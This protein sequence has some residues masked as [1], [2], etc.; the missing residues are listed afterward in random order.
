M[1]PQDQRS[2][3][4]MESVLSNL[5]TPF[6]PDNLTSKSKDKALHTSRNNIGESKRKAAIMIDDRTSGAR[7]LG[8]VSSEHKKLNLLSQV[9]AGQRTQ[10]TSTILRPLPNARCV[11]TV[12]NIDFNIR[13][14]LLP[15]TMTTCEFIFPC[16]SV[17][18][19]DLLEQREQ[20]QF[21]GGLMRGNASSLE[22][23]LSI[24][25]LLKRP[26]SISLHKLSYPGK[27]RLQELLTQSFP[28]S[29]SLHNVFTF[30]IHQRLDYWLDTLRRAVSQEDKDCDSNNKRVLAAL[31]DVQSSINV[32]SDLKINFSIN[33]EQ[34]SKN[35]DQS[36]ASEEIMMME[37]QLADTLKTMKGGRL[38]SADV[39]HEEAVTKSNSWGTTVAPQGIN[40]LL[41]PDIE[42]RTTS[43]K[44]HPSKPLAD[45]CTN[46][47][48][49]SK[50]SITVPLLFDASACVTAQIGE[51]L[52]HSQTVMFRA[53]GV[54]TAYYEAS[55]LTR[56]ELYLNTD[57]LFACL[58]RE[59]RSVARSAAESVLLNA[60]TE[61]ELLE[62]STAGLYHHH[63]VA[64]K[65]NKDEHRGPS[66]T[67]LVSPRA[68]V[69]A[70]VLP[71]R[72]THRKYGVRSL[73]GSPP[74]AVSPITI[75]TT[76]PR[77]AGSTDNTPPT[78]TVAFR[79]LPLV[80]P[81]PSKHR[82]L[83]LPSFQQQKR[84]NFGPNPFVPVFRSNI[85]AHH[86]T[87]GST[88]VDDVAGALTALKHSN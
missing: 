63:L 58:E 10:N 23:R 74:I 21:I 24:S 52:E 80:S 13:D 73:L 54:V 60:V 83:N 12:G 59:A 40:S 51:E 86:N 55:S 32:H 45:G 49:A 3:G 26:A 18:G 31:L 6:P 7:R 41:F 14:G 53:E 46:C 66:S 29:Q 11:T 2:R 85:T 48:D 33:G 70:P 37:Q 36:S 65:S 1:T 64:I 17:H 87:G 79:N 27:L 72:D 38:T 42:P 82:L 88:I 25:A 35:K 77:Q 81:P 39:I 22:D 34:E 67:A 47:D 76:A 68:A 19:G 61:Q 43:I 84:K 15:G 50:R 71:K 56:I 30:L 8:T 4:P 9:S 44:Q 28:A 75:T 57:E 78:P 69:T 62:S 16:L 5:S 20:R